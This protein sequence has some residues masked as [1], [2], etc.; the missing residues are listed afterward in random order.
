MNTKHAFEPFTTTVGTNGS[1]TFPVYDAADGGIPKLTIGPKYAHNSFR[2]FVKM[3]TLEEC[4]GLPAPMN[5]DRSTISFD[6]EFLFIDGPVQP[7]YTGHIYR[8]T[9]PDQVGRIRKKRFHLW[10]PL[11][12]SSIH[13]ALGVKI[14]MLQPGQAIEF[15]GASYYVN[16]NKKARRKKDNYWQGLSPTMPMAKSQ[17]PFALM[18]M[19]KLHYLPKTGFKKRFRTAK[20]SP[21]DWTNTPEAVRDMPENNEEWIPG[22]LD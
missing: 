9:A 14:G 15:F 2:F 10:S 3:P 12:A 20:G 21:L 16:L 19:V 8:V 1:V 17:Q 7:G 11:D 18:L 22:D 4:A 6:P 13:S 5:A